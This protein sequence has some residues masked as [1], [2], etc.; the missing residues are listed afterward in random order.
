MNAIGKALHPLKSPVGHACRDSYG[1]FFKRRLGGM[2]IEEVLIAPQSA[3]QNPY[4]ER[5][6]GSIRRECIARQ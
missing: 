3:W 5:V 1:E 2:N 6:I 4:V